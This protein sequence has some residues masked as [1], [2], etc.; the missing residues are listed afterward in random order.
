MSK[1]WNLVL[2]SNVTL[3]SLIFPELRPGY[4]PTWLEFNM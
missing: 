2:R 3:S 1:E 4:K